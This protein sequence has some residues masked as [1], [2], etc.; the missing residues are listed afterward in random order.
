MNSL[1]IKTKKM[2]TKYFIGY[3]NNNKIILLFLKFPQ[4]IYFSIN[5]KKSYAYRL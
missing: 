5:L 3:K 2:D 4:L 1:M